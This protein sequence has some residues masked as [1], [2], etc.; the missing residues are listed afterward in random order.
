MSK[1]EIRRGKR[2]I[3]QDLQHFVAPDGSSAHPAGFEVRNLNRRNCPLGRSLVSGEK[4]S[5]EISAT[6]GRQS[7]SPST[8]LARVLRGR[9]ANRLCSKPKN[10][11]SARD[12][13]FFV[14]HRRFELLTPTL[15]VL[16]ATNCA[17]AP[18]SGYII[19]SGAVCKAVFS[20]F[21]VLLSVMPGIHPGIPSPAGAD[22]PAGRC[23]RF[24]RAGPRC[25]RRTGIPR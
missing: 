10:Q 25:S 21:F 9:R 3:R 11:T 17:N 6:S 24:A 4:S 13:W 12:V 20:D 19:I 8:A 16:C 23:G 15:P 2:K 22:L 5:V 7:F 18:N 1:Y 14:E